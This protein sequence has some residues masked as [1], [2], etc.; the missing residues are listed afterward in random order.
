M[1]ISVRHWLLY[2]NPF[3]I[4]CVHWEIQKNRTPSC[5][6]KC[7]PLY[8]KNYTDDLI[9]CKLTTVNDQMKLLLQLAKH[10]GWEVSRSTR[11]RLIGEWLVR[12]QADNQINHELFRL[13]RRRS[14]MRCLKVRKRE[15]FKY[16]CLFRTLRNN[17][18][19][20]CWASTEDRTNGVWSSDGMSNHWRII[21]SL[22]F[23]F[24]LRYYD[25][26]SRILVIHE[27]NGFF[28][29][30]NFRFRVWRLDVFPLYE[31]DRMG[32][33]RRGQVL[34]FCQLLGKELGR[35]W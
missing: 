5:D 14:K 34:D 21:P 16:L 1:W 26:W 35:E 2:G 19:F 31:S 18:Y 3:E 4:D 24:D 33:R 32:R 23:R 11:N 8:R 22:W 6:E 29:S 28:F 17:I 30:R 15:G 27:D 25:A 10:I 9:K 20:R 7:N 13:N 12:R